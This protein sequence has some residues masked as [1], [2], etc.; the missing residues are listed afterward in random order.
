MSASVPGTSEPP[1]N[2]STGFSPPITIPNGLHGI[3]LAPDGS[4]P[5]TIIVHKRG[6][7]RP[8]KYPRPGEPL[9]IYVPLEPTEAE[10]AK[11]RRAGRP[12]KRVKPEK[13]DID[14][15]AIKL[16]EFESRHFALEV[17]EHRI[18]VGDDRFH[19][20]PAMSVS[21]FPEFDASILS[22]REKKLKTHYVVS[23]LSEP[24]PLFWERR[25]YDTGTR[26]ASESEKLKARIADIQKEV[27]TVRRREERAARKVRRY[28]SS[29]EDSDEYGEEESE[30]SATRT[31]PV[32]PLRMTHVRT[33]SVGLPD[34]AESEKPVFVRIGTR[35]FMTD[36]S[37]ATDVDEL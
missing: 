7:G 17:I 37:D 6:R 22:Y 23:N 18:Q 12:S 32:S 29:T 35:N 25:V 21:V 9:V 5:R 3:P 36:D 19:G 33:R 20:H 4:M 27:D 14:A 1:R 15:D 30:A 26:T 28:A 16:D 10:Q 8:R 13:P 31:P 2:L 24:R 34:D 11:K